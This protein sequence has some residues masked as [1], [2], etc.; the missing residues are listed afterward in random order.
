MPKEPKVDYSGSAIPKPGK[1]ERRPR[2]EIRREKKL[3]RNKDRMA[4]LYADQYG[5]AAV[6]VR[7][8]PD[9]GR[10]PYFYR[11]AASVMLEV[12]QAYRV[13]QDAIGKGED[14]PEYSDP[15][16]VHPKAGSDQFDLVPLTRKDHGDVEDHGREGFEAKHGVDLD[17]VARWIAG[18]IALL[19]DAPDTSQEVGEESP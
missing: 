1:R 19:L 14:P 9:V 17:L 10:H 4:W 18:P 16:H 12:A 6:V 7:A 15:H 3:G 2:A 11:D 8:M 13:V 5:E